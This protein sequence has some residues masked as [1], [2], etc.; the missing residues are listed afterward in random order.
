MEQL[1]E[2]T[3]TEKKNEREK[4][5]SITHCLYL[6]I[7]LEWGETTVPEL[8]PASSSGGDHRGQ[9]PKHPEQRQTE[10]KT[11]KDRRSQD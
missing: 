3:R 4:Q 7:V 8:F 1:K 9:S 2:E 11:Q 5:D 6:L 10:K